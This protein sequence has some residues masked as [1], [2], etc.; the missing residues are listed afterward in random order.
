MLTQCA[1]LLQDQ[2]VYLTKVFPVP[3][4]SFAIKE[5]GGGKKA[6]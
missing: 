4:Y 3:D 1:D 5:E 2:L 6:M